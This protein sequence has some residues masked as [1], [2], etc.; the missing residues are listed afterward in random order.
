[1][2]MIGEAGFFDL[3]KKAERR[4]DDGKQLVQESATFLNKQFLSVSIRKRRVG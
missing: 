3:Y 1:M 4:E 2:E